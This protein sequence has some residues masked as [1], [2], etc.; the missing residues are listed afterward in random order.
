MAKLSELKDLV[1]KA[2]AAAVTT[3]ASATRFTGQQGTR[4]VPATDPPES[5]DPSSV[6]PR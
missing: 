3:P 2:R 1:A 5:G 4:G 6:V